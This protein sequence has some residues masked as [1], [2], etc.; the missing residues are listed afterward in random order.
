MLKK[1]AKRG[2]EDKCLIKPCFNQKKIYDYKK[3]T[4]DVLSDAM[5][6]ISTIILTIILTTIAS[7]IWSTILTLRHY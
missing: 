1:C 7:T 4:I 6:L 2:K 5:M 3:M